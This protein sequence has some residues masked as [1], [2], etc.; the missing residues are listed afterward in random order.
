MAGVIQIVI[1]QVRLAGSVNTGR[2]R[3]AGVGMII[4]VE[5]DFIIVSCVNVN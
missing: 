2:P 1:V 5:R 3:L 4:G